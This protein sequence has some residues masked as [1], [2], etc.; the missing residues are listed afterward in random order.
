METVNATWNIRLTG[1]EILVGRKIPRRTQKSPHANLDKQQNQTYGWTPIYINCS[2]L[3]Q[4][5][6]IHKWQNIKWPSDKSVWEN[7]WRKWGS[8]FA[9][10]WPGPWS[11]EGLNWASVRFGSQGKC[12]VVHVPDVNHNVLYRV[13]NNWSREKWQKYLIF[14][15]TIKYGRLRWPASV[16]CGGLRPKKILIIFFIFIFFSVSLKKTK[17]RKFN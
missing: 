3:F 15:F 14:T 6:R 12:K 13:S 9:W 8:E 7:I 10:N 17:S 11:G 4:E 2:V 1:P 16:S 5:T